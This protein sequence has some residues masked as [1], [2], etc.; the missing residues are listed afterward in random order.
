M[1]H[2]K[3]STNFWIAGLNVHIGPAERGLRGS[4][5]VRGSRLNPALSLC[6]TAV[7]VLVYSAIPHDSF[8]FGCLLILCNFQ[9]C[10]WNA[11][12]VG[13]SC[14]NVPS[15]SWSNCCNG[16]K[17]KCFVAHQCTRIDH[18][19]QT[20]TLYTV[21]CIASSQLI[22]GDSKSSMRLLHRTATAHIS[23]AVKCLII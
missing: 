2:A 1:T 19:I 22:S 6:A 10:Y 7:G 9:Q 13:I 21:Q 4:L 14:W 20:L 18:S 3:N 16:H 11:L 15:W 23:I 17:N 5:K 12:A 8:M